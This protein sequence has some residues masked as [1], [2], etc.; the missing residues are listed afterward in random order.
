MKRTAGLL[1][2]IALATVVA[3]AAQAVKAKPLDLTRAPAAASSVG[4]NLPATLAFDN[5]TRTRWASD[6]RKAKPAWIYVDLGGEYTI[7]RVDIDWEWSYAHDY[8][9][10]VAGGDSAPDPDTSLGSWT[11]IA[12]ITGRS[13]LGYRENGHTAGGNPAGKGGNTSERFDFSTKT[14]K[15]YYGAATSSVLTGG[16]GRF[17]MLHVTDSI[18][19][20]VSPWEI[21]VCVV[22]TA[23]SA[24]GTP[25]KDPGAVAAA[26]AE[27][28]PPE[29]PELLQTRFGVDKLL[30]VKR[31]TLTA[32]HY[33]TEFINSAW[34]PG[35]NLCLLDLK[36]GNVTDLVPELSGGVFNRFDL[37]FDADRVVF[38]WKCAA[39]QGYRIYE[40]EL[41]PTTGRRRGKL[42]QLTFPREDESELARLYRARPHYHH[43]TDDMNPCYLPDGGICF[44]STRCQYGILC[45]G[46]DDFTTTVL[47]RM[48]ADG[49]NMK[50]LSDSPLSEASP[51]VLPDGRIMYT[52][53]EY[54]DK[55]AISVKCLWAMRPDGTGSSE[56][57]G[58]DIFY[59]HTILY[60][61]PIPGEPNLYSALGLGHCCPQNTVGTIIRIDTSKP[62]RSIEPLTYITDE[63]RIKPNGHGGYLWKGKMNS[64]D[65]PLYRDPFPLRKDLY[66]AAHKPAGPEWSAPAAYDL[67][68]VNEQGDHHLIHD[69]PDYSCWQ[70]IPLRKRARPPVLPGPR[71]P[72]YAE[73]DQA[74]CIVAD[75]HEGMTG[76]RRGEVKYLRILLQAARPWAAR[77]RWGGDEYDQQ[78]AVVTK[79]THLGLKALV[80]IVPVEEDG[81]AHFVVPAGKNVYFQALDENYLCLQS[82]RTIVNYMPGEVRAC[83]GCHETPDVAPPSVPGTLA[84][85]RRPP[86]IPRPQPGDRSAAR[87]LHY[88]VDVQPVWDKHCVKCHNDQK[89]AG[90]LNLSGRESALFSVS[91]EQL[92]EERRNGGGRSR[93][94]IQLVPTI[95]ENWPKWGNVHYL[96]PRSLWSHA[97]VLVGMLMPDKVRW[98][99]DLDDPRIEQLPIL[100]AEMAP[101]HFT[102]VI[103]IG[104][105]GLAQ[106]RK[107]FAERL[108]GMKEHQNLGITREEL[109]RVTTWIDA[110]AYYYGSYW[111]RRNLKYREH[112]N[113]RPVP[114]YEDAL[115]RTPALPEDDR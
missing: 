65:C 8:T 112:P 41:D 42:R 33:Y 55:G 98:Q 32:D 30:F 96:E 104:T 85:M 102:S 36:T 63:V 4:W 56:I 24:A 72:V 17:L 10:R 27:K 100:K 69:D 6:P 73:K 37:G 67:Y 114:T 80:G 19:A 9:L 60:G 64:G 70:P 105:R 75:V 68:V 101:Y 66:L 49:K 87:A 12:A 51:C 90:G 94:R 31:K 78:H 108:A 107:E 44:I 21:R 74:V 25:G 23:N 45:D 20:H 40:I 52:R 106:K 77:R 29:M 95:G 14:W 61:R 103:E 59:P 46:S 84:A 58:N 35:G 71:D 62:I 3:E 34:M 113:Y 43:G 18:G 5:D 81:S 11:T 88:P 83:I 13:N 79:D 89:A 22:P 86:S 111:G 76:I 54:N 16:T 93:N 15:P 109:L 48:D 53:W 115:R 1:S 38:E 47:Y 28:A 97:S 110:N 39:Q 26:V 82:E 57:Y 2:I 92:I 50:K 99:T 91:Y 7:G